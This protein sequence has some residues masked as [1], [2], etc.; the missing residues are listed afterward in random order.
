M[1]LNITC[2]YLL[3]FKESEAEEDNIS[4]RASIIHNCFQFTFLQLSVEELHLV[5]QHYNIVSFF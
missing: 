2:Q 3:Q 1:R 4:Q 5:S